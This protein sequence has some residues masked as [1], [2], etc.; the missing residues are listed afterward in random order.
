MLLHPG[1][2]KQH[3]CLFWGRQLQCQLRRLAGSSLPERLYNQH[4]PSMLS[5]RRGCFLGGIPTFIATPIP[6]EPTSIPIGTRVTA[7]VTSV[8][9]TQPC[10]YAPD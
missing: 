2:P 5:I 10:W 1:I 6:P 9:T 8:T 4:T 7:S 3:D